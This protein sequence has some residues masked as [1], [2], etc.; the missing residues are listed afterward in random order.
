MKWNDLTLNDLTMER[1]D[2][3]THIVLLLLYIIN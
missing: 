2:H 3:K 1:G